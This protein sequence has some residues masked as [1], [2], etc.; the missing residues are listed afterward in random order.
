M[1][2]SG[3]RQVLLEMVRTGKNS[4][5]VVFRGDIF[6][7]DK[8]GY[9]ILLGFLPLW[10]FLLFGVYWFRVAVLLLVCVSA[11]MFFVYPTHLRTNW[12]SFDDQ[13]QR[14]M[15]ALRQSILYQKLKAIQ[16]IET[17]GHLWVFGSSRWLSRI[18]LVHAV[19]LAEKHRLTEELAKRFPKE[20]LHYKKWSDWRGRLPTLVMCFIP[21]IV[22]SCMTY[23][24]YSTFPEVRLVP[25]RYNLKTEQNLSS[26]YGEYSLEHFSFSVP[27]C[28]ELIEEE[29]Q[30]LRFENQVNK[31]TL[32]VLI[33][34]SRLP[35]VEAT[36]FNKFIPLHVL[37]IRDYYDLFR[38]GYYA[39]LGIL[40]LMLKALMLDES[41][42]ASI[43]EIGQDDLKGFLTLGKTNTKNIAAI[44]L[45]DKNK[46]RELDFYLTSSEPIDGETLAAIIA[47]VQT[48][49]RSG[50]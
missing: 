16:I 10:S 41:N 14:I 1:Q 50:D 17:L 28:F 23:W 32:S 19:D 11:S 21:L 42:C 5:R 24:V 13:N 30:K 38:W 48:A 8:Y 47:S 29:E 31:R 22:F 18:P 46:E 35:D 39:R 4:Q 34:P 2:N 33:N 36:V 20:K 45:V 6:K 9:F 25:Q 49:E 43:Y 37:G 12:L 27:R 7:V 26:A 44:M 3:N 40:P 15:M